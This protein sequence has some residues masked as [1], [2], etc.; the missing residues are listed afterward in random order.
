MISHFTEIDAELLFEQIDEAERFAAA[1]GPRIYAVEYH[2][3][4]LPVLPEYAGQQQDQVEQTPVTALARRFLHRVN[5]LQALL[6]AQAPQ[7][8][9]LP[10]VPQNLRGWLGAL[11]LKVV[12][13]CS[14]WHMRQVTDFAGVVQAGFTE[15]AAMMHILLQAMALNERELRDLRVEVTKLRENP[16]PGITAPD[17]PAAMDLSRLYL[18]FQNAF[19]GSRDEVKE[20]NRNYLPY[21]QNSCL[22]S[23]SFPAIDIGCG[24]GEWLELLR[25]NN[26][27]CLGSDSD[28]V[29]TEVCEK[30]GLPVVM[31]DGI[32]YLNILPAAS[33]GAVTAFHVVEHMT[34][35]QFLGLLVS[36]RRALKPGG[37]LILETP[38]PYNLTV[39]A[40]SFHLDPT[41]LR[42]MPAEILRHFSEAVGFEHI[43]TLKLHPNPQ[44][45]P[46]ASNTD[47]WLQ[48]L[49]PRIHGARDCALIARR[50]ES[51]CNSAQ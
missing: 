35:N 51:Q 48:D 1:F 20:R 45:P 39:G 36:A 13:R 25:E 22:I 23:E 4:R 17:P 10:P 21:L 29:M 11:L 5:D 44:F 49:Y 26:L 19:R 31:R 43:A 41:H 46:P 14:W 42:P 16:K 15:S 3:Y 28:P 34:F 27:P 37:L 38:D 30:L 2:P 12:A 33:I 18:G 8:D 47:L 6:G 40:Y 50:G 9:R 24:R 7:A 32:E